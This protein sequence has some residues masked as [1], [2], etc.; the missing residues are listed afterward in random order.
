MWEGQE[1]A[2]GR[3]IHM[4]NLK[5]IFSHLFNPNIPLLKEIYY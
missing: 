1:N 4:P 5:H 2:D 3:P